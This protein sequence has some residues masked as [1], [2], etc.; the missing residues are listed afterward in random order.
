MTISVIS[1]PK[2]LSLDPS[3][4]SQQYPCKLGFYTWSRDLKEINIILFGCESFYFCFEANEMRH[5]L[6][7]YNVMHY[8]FETMSKRLAQRQV[9]CYKS[10]LLSNV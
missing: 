3:Q 7:E 4:D 1:N 9:C 2:V 5:S 10:D 8:H 6:K